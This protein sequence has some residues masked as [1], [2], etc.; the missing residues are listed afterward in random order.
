MNWIQRFLD[1]ELAQAVNIKS[2]QTKE[3]VIQGLNTAKRQATPGIC[4]YINGRDLFAWD[5]GYEGK[6][7]KYYCDSVNYI[8][9]PARDTFT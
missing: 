5:S 7:F 6:E 2:K 8:E 1:K 3:S 9:P 4:L